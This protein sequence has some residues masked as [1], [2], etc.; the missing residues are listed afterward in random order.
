LASWSQPA[1]PLRLFDRIPNKRAFL[2]WS[3]EM[4]GVPRLLERISASQQPVLVVLTYHRIAVP[5]RWSNPY[6]DPVISASPE[7]FEAHMSLVARRFCSVTLE[8]L[9]DQYTLKAASS[10]TGKPVVLVTFDDGYRDNFETALP[11]LSKFDVPAA[12]FIP[13]RFL[14]RPVLPWWDHVAYVLKQTQVRRLAL[15]R[16][17]DDPDPVEICLDCDSDERGRTAAIMQVIH[18]FLEGAI[19]EEGW[20]LAQLQ[21]QAYVSLDAQALGRDLFMSWAQLRALN[22]AGM[23]IGSHGHTHMALERLDD[24]AQR[25]ELSESKRILETGLGR[26][27][28]AVAYPFGWQ[29]TFTSRTQQLADEAGYR[30]GFSSLEGVNHPGSANFES[31]CVRRLNVG[32]GDSTP[33]LRARAALYGAFGGSSL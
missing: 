12:F 25:F 1:L 2:A 24:E 26:E 11:I 21:E 16:H 5:G 20:F 27:V 6:Y 32:A 30:L 4:I 8:Q 28:A 17:L 29:G 10:R 31:L 19:P 15:R 33:L 18:L 7:A 22:T 13:T 3:L 14:D 23:S 9:H